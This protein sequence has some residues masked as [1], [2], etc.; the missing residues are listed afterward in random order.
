MHFDRFGRLYEPVPGLLVSLEID[1]EL[2]QEFLHVDSV[3]DGHEAG[4]KILGGI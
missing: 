2:V 1:V 3:L 4:F